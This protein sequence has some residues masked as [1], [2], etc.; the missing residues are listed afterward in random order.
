MRSK[1]RYIPF[2]TLILSCILCVTAGAMIEVYAQFSPVLLSR[3]KATGGFDGSFANLDIGGWP[4]IGYPGYQ[5]SGYEFYQGNQHGIVVWAER[6]KA[7]GAGN[8]AI[9]FVN[10]QKKYF[11]IEPVEDATLH[12]NYNFTAS[13][14]EPEEYITARSRIPEYPIE[15]DA[16]WMSWSLPRYDD[17]ILGEIEVINTGNKPLKN[18]RFGLVAPWVQNHGFGRSDQKFIWNEE[19]KA[20][21]FYDDR[22]FDW[23]TGTPT[24]YAFG[25]GPQTGDA[26]DPM[27]IT[28]PNSIR[29]ELRSP[30]VY[31]LAGLVV[32]PDK[33]GG[34]ALHYNILRTNNNQDLESGL[35]T[36]EARP[37]PQD[38]PSD[39]LAKLTYEQPRMSWDEA[40]ADPSTPD[41]NRWE[42]AP[43]ELISFGPYDL[44]PGQSV[45][46]VVG[47]IFGQ[48]DRAS[49]VEGG[50]KNTTTFVE[51]GLDALYEN[52]DAALELIENDYRPTAYP[53]PTIGEKGDY[54][55]VT[56]QPGYIEIAFE[57]IPGSYVDP[58]K[59]ANDVAGYKVYRSNYSMIGP[60][61]VIADI[62]YGESESGMVTVKDEDVTLGI[63]YYYTVSSYDEDGLESSPIAYNR[64][65]V[66]PQRAPGADDAS[67]TYVVPNPFRVINRLIDSNEWNKIVFVNVP[68]QCTIR[69][70]TI[71]G[72][73]VREIHHD[74]GSGEQSWGSRASLDLMATRYWKQPQ[75]GVYVYQ[76]VSEVPGSEGE[77]FIGKLA[78]IR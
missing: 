72:D 24:E 44:A 39:I 57:P 61:E 33:D 46:V 18:L 34:D 7:D 36:A 40:A 60:W 22:A 48:M 37:L 49:I 29:H 19:R 76:V 32:P 5:E 74:D 6:E 51:R 21:I 3:G 42:R 78:I 25:P 35:P 41:G 54:L 45:E 2:R 4:R 58:I 53:P 11:S 47:W 27:D 28:V 38:T 66:I 43:L 17:F 30:T 10:F 65:G 9:A 52:W 14:S 12:K 55:A 26:G 8:E 70:Y 59:N 16:R 75:P 68:S 69:I 23:E 67:E 71:A 56:A 63:S 1:N 20:F 13:L 15:I 62:P 77:T 50:V 73:L 31:T 64:Y